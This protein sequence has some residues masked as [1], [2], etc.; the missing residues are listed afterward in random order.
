MPP[1]CTIGIGIAFTN[2]SI[3]LGSG[4]LFLT[5]LSAISFAG[6]ITFALM[7]FSPVRQEKSTRKIPHSI[8]L[9]AL[10]VIIITI[11]LVI[12]SWNTI[13]SARFERKVKNVL[14]AQISSIYNAQLESIDI[15]DVDG[16]KK[17]T[18]TVRA[19][20]SLTFVEVSSVQQMLA[21]VTQKPIALEMVVIP[22]SSL[23]T[24]TLLHRRRHS[25][26][27]ATTTPLQHHNRSYPFST[28]YLNPHAGFHQCRP[29]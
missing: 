29:Q 21:A 12:L 9:S 11:P 24:L 23:D 15:Q 17:V 3:F 14:T 27:T 1:L 28:T 4:L 10:F 20:R 26:P 5:N 8:L 7:G 6:I 2:R 22:V 16:T 19:A 18:A 25:T 13:S